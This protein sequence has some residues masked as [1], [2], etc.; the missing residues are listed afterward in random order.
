MVDIDTSRIEEHMDVI[1]A[2]GESIGKVDHMQDGK[3]KLTKN[4]S[5]DHQHHFVPLLWIDHIDQHVHLNK[6]LSD[7][8]AATGSASSVTKTDAVPEVGLHDAVPKT[9]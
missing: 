6:T 2:D 1:A 7:I 9:A 4:D 8:R 5:P 3:I